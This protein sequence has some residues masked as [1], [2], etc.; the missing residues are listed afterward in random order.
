MKFFKFPQ[1][2]LFGRLGFFQFSKRQ[3]F[4][5]LVLLL[6]G[7]MFVSEFFQGIEHFAITL[8]FSLLTV[9]LLY[10]VLRKDLKNTFFYPLFILPFLY[11]FSFGIFYLLIPQ[12]ILTMVISTAIYSFGLYSLFLTQ[13]IFAVSSIRTI[14]LLRSARIVSFVLTILVMFF[15]INII[16]SLQFP[17]YV[18]PFLIGLASFFLNIQSLWVYVLDRSYLKD[19]LLYSVVVSIAIAQLSF[20]LAMWSTSA[21]VYS[22][23]L[24]GM[25]YTYSGLSHAWIEKRLFRGIMWEYV[26]V[27]FLS[28]F[29][30]LVFSEFGI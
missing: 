1:I 28:I 16:F 30:L 9:V 3:I 5:V 2:R 18:A 14:S 15:L 11:T 20:T 23:F 19:I 7:G 10:F 24:T 22:I 17:F 4:V 6:S 13:N 27:A 8:F 29:I 25:F 26:W 12:R 21:A